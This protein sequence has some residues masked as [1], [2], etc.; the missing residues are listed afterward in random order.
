MPD[1]FAPN[2]DYYVYCV[3]HTGNGVY[4]AFYPVNTENSI[5]ECTAIAIWGSLPVSLLPRLTMRGVIPSLS[6]IFAFL[7]DEEL[8]SV[9]FMLLSGNSAMK[10]KPNPAQ[11]WKGTWDSRRLRLTEFLGKRHVKVTRLSALRPGH[12]YPLPP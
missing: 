5:T 4:P 12:L 3:A 1:N 9:A 2:R 8:D 7:C 6:K 10:V 11:A